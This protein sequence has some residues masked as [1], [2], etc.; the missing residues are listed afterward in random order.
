LVEGQ[1]GQYE[2]NLG[3][4]VQATFLPVNTHELP[5]V[6]EQMFVGVLQHPTKFQAGILTRK[7]YSWRIWKNPL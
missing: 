4:A 2:K 5:Q 1:T 6:A 3:A 7:F